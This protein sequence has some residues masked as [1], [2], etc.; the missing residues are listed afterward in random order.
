LYP[1]S[2]FV[3]RLLFYVLCYSIRNWCVLVSDF[4]RAPEKV[5]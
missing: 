2:D 4:P 3:V 5:A 1:C